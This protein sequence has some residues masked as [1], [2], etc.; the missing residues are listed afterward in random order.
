MPGAGPVHQPALVPPWP[1]ELS[2]RRQEVASGVSGAGAV[3]S[4]S[5]AATYARA[6]SSAS[7]RTRSSSGSIRSARSKS[8]SA[9]SDSPW[10]ARAWARRT[11]GRA[12]RPPVAAT[13]S[14]YSANS[15][16]HAPC[17]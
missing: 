1:Q 11:Y 2:L 4:P 12:S 6:H 17:S 15:A 3:C 16:S 7:S 5:L 14:S 10:A 9:R 13:A 8:W